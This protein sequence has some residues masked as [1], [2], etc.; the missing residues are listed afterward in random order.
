MEE[1]KEDNDSSTDEESE[2]S[3]EYSDVECLEESD[4]E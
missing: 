1:E 3:E 2:L 4:R